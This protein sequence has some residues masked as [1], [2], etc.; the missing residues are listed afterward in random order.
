MPKVSVVVPAYNSMV[1]LPQTID[2]IL[3]QT[4]T[5]FELLVINYEL[6]TQDCCSKNII[7]TEV[8]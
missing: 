8:N 7:C 2:S 5:D 6:K 1:Y 4:F 3:S